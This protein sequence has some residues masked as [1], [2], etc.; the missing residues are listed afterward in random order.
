MSKAGISDNGEQ[1]VAYLVEALCYKPKLA[2][3]VSDEV[4]GFFN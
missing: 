2:G 3:S 4:I 1:A